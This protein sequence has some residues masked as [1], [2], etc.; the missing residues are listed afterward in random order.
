MIPWL[1]PL[2]RRRAT[3]LTESRVERGKRRKKREALR[4]CSAR[5]SPPR[6]HRPVRVGD[7]TAVVACQ[8]GNAPGSLNQPPPTTIGFK[9]LSG[10]IFRLLTNHHSSRPLNFASIKRGAKAKLDCGKKKK[11][12]TS[13]KKGGTMSSSGASTVPL[14][15]PYKMGKFDLSH[16]YALFF[17][18]GS[19]WRQSGQTR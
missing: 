8:S 13:Q 10:I 19:C 4:H 5:D 17:A 16:R 6:R 7:L 9:C 3:G 1:N 15:T 18:G 12:R 14:L 11:T 2:R